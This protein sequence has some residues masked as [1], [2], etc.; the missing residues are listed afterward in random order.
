MDVIIITSSELGTCSKVTRLDLA[1]PGF[2][3]GPCKAKAACVQVGR[4]D[5]AWVWG[6]TLNAG[7]I[8][9]S[10]RWEI[11]LQPH[12]YPTRSQPINMGLHFMRQGVNLFNYGGD[13]SILS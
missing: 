6:P 9:E 11:I 12:P 3:L 2:K 8:K 13:S 10:R 7:A 5:P 1:E 4:H